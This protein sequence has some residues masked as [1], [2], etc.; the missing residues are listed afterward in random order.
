MDANDCSRWIRR[1]LLLAT[2]SAAGCGRTVVDPTETTPTPTPIAT[3]ATVGTAC[4][5]GAPRPME[6]FTANP[7]T[8]TDGETFTLSWSAPC[9]FVSLAQKGKPQFALYQ[10]ASGTYQLRSGLDGYPVATGDT[11]YEATNGDIAP[12]LSVTVTV[13]PKAPPPNPDSDG[14]GIPNDRDNCPARANPDQIDTDGDGLG[15]A[16]DPTPGG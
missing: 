7:T 4:S 2:V 8:I 14:D 16:C 1:F 10:P 5:A 11:I 9:G 15:D 13:N 3:P 6:S 12:R